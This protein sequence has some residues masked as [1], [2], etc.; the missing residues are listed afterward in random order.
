ML[1]PAPA[2]SSASALRRPVRLAGLVDAAVWL[3][4]ALAPLVWAG[5]LHPGLELL[6]HQRMTLA[7]SLALGAGWWAW[8]RRKTVTLAAVLALALGWPALQGLTLQGLTHLQ[9]PPNAGD[10]L[11]QVVQLNVHTQNPHKDQ[12]LAL[13]RQTPAQLLALQEVDAAWL[14]ALAPLHNQYPYRVQVARHDNFGIALWSALPLDATQVLDPGDL[15]VP[16]LAATVVVDGQ[17][18]RVV[19]THPPPPV[20]PLGHKERDAQLAGLARELAATQGPVLLMGDLNASPWS[21]AFADLLATAQLQDPAQQF[22]PTG[23]WPANLPLGRIW[24]D[25][26]LAGHGAR[27]TARSVLDAVGSDHLPVRATVTVRAGAR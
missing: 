27:V 7:A 8:Q 2:P 25:H 24:I 10:G 4:V 3:A 26:V 12:V 6:S 18:L 15:G 1:P 21:P 23:T 5:R 16:S 13:L 22:W 20:P 11:L 19:V 14:D 17:P 9:D